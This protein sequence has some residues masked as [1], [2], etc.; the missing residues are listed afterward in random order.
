MLQ[1]VSNV[2]LL[3][4]RQSL[5]QS[6]FGKTYTASVIILFKWSIYLLH[7]PKLLQSTHRYGSMVH[8]IF[9]LAHFMKAGQQI[10]GVPHPYC[11]GYRLGVGFPR[12][13]TNIEN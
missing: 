12:Q 1:S 9:E 8:G 10:V 7:G 3:V 6:T 13:C 4:L 2:R 11:P 5:N